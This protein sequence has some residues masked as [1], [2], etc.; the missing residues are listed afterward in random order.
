MGVYIP[1]VVLGAV[2]AGI[3]MLANYIGSKGDRD[4]SER[5]R[6]YAFGAALVTAA[7][8]AILVVLVAVDTPNRFTDAITTIL[9]ICVFFAILLVVLF[10]ISQVVGLVTRRAGR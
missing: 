6:D 2:Y 8:A 4:R 10:L 9:V 7:Y 1:L 5:F 3:T